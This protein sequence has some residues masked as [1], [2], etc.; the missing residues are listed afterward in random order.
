MKVALVSLPSLMVDQ[1]ESLKPIVKKG[2]GQLDQSEEILIILT[3]YF[4]FN[5]LLK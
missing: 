1:Q 5:F 4:L 2:I 3:I